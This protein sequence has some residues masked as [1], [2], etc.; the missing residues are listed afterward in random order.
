MIF[1]QRAVAIHND[2]TE[3]VVGFEEL[4]QRL[5]VELVVTQVERRVNRLEGLKIDVHFLLLVVI[6]EYGA[7]IDDETV[8]RHFGE[9]FEALLRGGY[10]GE[11]GEAVDT[12]LDVRR[13]P[14]LVG[15]HLRRCGNLIYGRH[16]H[17]CLC[18]MLSAKFSGMS[19]T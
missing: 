1:V 2:E 19:R 3:L 18:L 13:C 17:P 16:S 9:E 4:L 7:A 10:C 8:R 6:G 14:E 11:N 5:C 12:R 15:E